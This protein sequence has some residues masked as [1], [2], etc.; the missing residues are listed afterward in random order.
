MNVPGWPAMTELRTTPLHGLHVEL[1]A[2][3]TPFA[4]WDMPVAFA[5]TLDEHAHTRRAASL[6]DV[7]HMAVLDVDASAAEDL[8]RLVPSAITTLGAGR[9]RYTVFTTDDGGILDD[10]IV[11][12]HGDHLG[13]VVNASRRGVVV[14]HLHSHLGA[15]AV[16]ERTD[17]ALL[18]LQGPEAVAVLADL[19]AEVGELFSMEATATEVAGVP[20]WLARSGYTGEDGGELRVPADRAGE[21][22]RAL[23]ADDRVR[24]AGLGARDT[25]RLEAGL[26]LYGNDL[27]ETTSP[28]EAGL[29][30][31][32]PR[33]RREE[34]GFAG[35][36]RILAELADGPARQRVGL[37]PIGRRPM[38]PPATLRGAEGG[39]VGTLTS[40]TFGPTVEAP[41]AMGYVTAGAAQ[42]GTEV[43]AD[44]RG[45]DV[46][47]QVVE[48]PFVPSGAVRRPR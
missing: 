37:R 17:T 38:R 43:V 28:I 5:G 18:A 42:V 35:A 32:I 27:D 7:S 8:E 9:C 20:V 16:T 3:M 46:T 11:T 4:G 23:L 26:C 15:A 21:L 12:N 25:L 29:A 30:W 31:T 10:A 24:P 34:G 14:P 45:S 33:R 36:E 13:L 41:V 44:I 1:G 6:F 22:A 19:G 47:A 40:G 2:K 48:L 39:E